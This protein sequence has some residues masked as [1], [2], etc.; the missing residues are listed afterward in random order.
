MAMTGANVYNDAIVGGERFQSRQPV[1]LRINK[2]RV[3]SL[4]GR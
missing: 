3:H 2:L 1:S 4:T